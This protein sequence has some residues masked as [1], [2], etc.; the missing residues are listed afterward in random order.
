MILG[1][2]FDILPFMIE[3][4]FG[5]EPP[6]RLNYRDAVLDTGRL[7]NVPSSYSD[8]AG[9]GRL[10]VGF[11]IPQERW[12]EIDAYDDNRAWDSRGIIYLLQPVSSPIQKAF[13]EAFLR[14][15][16]ELYDRLADQAKKAMYGAAMERARAVISGDWNRYDVQ[17]WWMFA[18][19][20]FE[21]LRAQMQMQGKAIF[22]EDDAISRIILWAD[23]GYSESEKETGRLHL[24]GL[25]YINT[26]PNNHDR[27]MYRLKTNPQGNSHIYT[28]QRAEEIVQ[29]YLLLSAQFDPARAF[30]H[31]Y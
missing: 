13:G 5:K 27:I 19:Y 12:E 8:R 23:S 4:G 24:R 16:K 11:N 29:S 30:G 6:Q 25:E 2:F 20:L 7:L 26:D 18:P 17:A 1:R 10:L 21:A 14:R 15:G 9:L 28:R 31:R 3:Q 22:D